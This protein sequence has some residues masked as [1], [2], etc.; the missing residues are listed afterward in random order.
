MQCLWHVEDL[1]DNNKAARFFMEK[2]IDIFKSN[3][4]LFTTE[5]HSEMKTCPGGPRT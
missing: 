1:I 5:N 3:D 2:A 4:S